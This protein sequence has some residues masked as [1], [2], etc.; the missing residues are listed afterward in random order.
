MYYN[1]CTFQ[2]RR[3]GHQWDGDLFISGGILDLHGGSQVVLHVPHTFILGVLS[4]IEL[5]KYSF[6]GGFGHIGQ[7]I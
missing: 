5:M 4:R 1:V 2:M 3:V 7:D 6:Q